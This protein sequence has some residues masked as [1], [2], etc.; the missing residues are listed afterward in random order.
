MSL[1]LILKGNQT[2]AGSGPTSCLGSQPGWGLPQSG[3]NIPPVHEADTPARSGCYQNAMRFRRPYLAPGLHAHLYA[4]PSL[5]FEGEVL[6][7]G[8]RKEALVVTGYFHA[9][10][11]SPEAEIR[12]EKTARRG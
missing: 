10:M 4:R 12:Q 3:Y 5:V 9:N 8:G 6:A 11:H 2:R 1:Y 7:A